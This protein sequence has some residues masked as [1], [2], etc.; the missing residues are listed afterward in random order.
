MK[1]LEFTY[2][3]ENILEIINKK[4]LKDEKEASTSTEKL[5]SDFSKSLSSIK[6]I[7]KDLQRNI[8]REKG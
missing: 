3:L 6:E 1:F 8:E 2:T 7:I 4:L 5:L